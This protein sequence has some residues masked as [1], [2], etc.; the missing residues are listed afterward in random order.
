[1]SLWSK[2]VPAK[3]NNL[4]NLQKEMNDFFDG[5]MKDPFMESFPAGTNFSPKLEIKE[6]EKAYHVCA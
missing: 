6:D 4:V 2:N 3:T 1:M 5:V